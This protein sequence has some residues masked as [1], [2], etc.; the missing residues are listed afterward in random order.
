MTR[1]AATRRN[2]NRHLNRGVS[3]LLSPPCRHA[4]GQKRRGLSPL[5]TLSP[6]HPWSL[7]TLSL[8]LEQLREEGALLQHQENALLIRPTHWRQM[9]RLSPSGK[10]FCFFCKQ[11][12]TVKI[13]VLVGRRERRNFGYGRQLSYAGPQALKD[14]FADGYF[15]TVKA[16]SDRWQAFVRWCRSEAAPLQRCTSHRSTD[17]TR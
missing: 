5:S 4:L 13:M 8:L 11:T 3:P 14:L 10:P 16:H 1:C 6:H 15:A 7:P 9:D 17:T 2:I 12:K